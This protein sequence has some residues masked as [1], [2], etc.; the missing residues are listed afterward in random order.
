MNALP[1]FAVPESQDR[2]DLSKQ[3]YF[4]I[5][6][7]ESLRALEQALEDDGFKVIVPA[8]GLADEALKR[9]ARGW[10]ILTRNSQDFVDE[11]VRYDYDVIGIEDI[12]FVDDR[13]DR[14]NETVRKI[15]AAVRRSQLNT[16]K[17]NF[18]LKVRD[19]G[20]FHLEQLV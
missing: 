10:A 17:G 7:D 20:A 16:R 19:N 18:W 1:E 3:G 12:K 4:T 11:A 8:Q 14:T 15:S 6:L 2:I 5:L 13:S 9:K